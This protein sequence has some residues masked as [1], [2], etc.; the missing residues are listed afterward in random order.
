MLLIILTA[1][2]G[3]ARASFPEITIY[4]DDDMTEI[5]VLCFL[6]IVVE[7]LRL[8]GM[9]VN[10]IEAIASRSHQQVVTAW[11]DDVI[12]TGRLDSR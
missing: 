4:V 2:N 6:G 9:Y 5:R 12:H 3:R 8:Q 11:L 7:F 1:G 10:L